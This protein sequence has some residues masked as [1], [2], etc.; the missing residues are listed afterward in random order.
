MPKNLILLHGFLGH[1]QEFEFL[2]QTLEERTKG[3][4]HCICLDLNL[5]PSYSLKAQADF[6]KKN[7]D[8]LNIT[9]SHFWGYSMGGRILLEFYKY[10]PQMCESL[11]LESVSLGIEDQKERDLRLQ[12]DIQWAQMIKTAPDTFLKE[13]YSQPLFENFKKCSDFDIYFL[14]RRKNLSSLHAKMI[15]E[16]SPGANT[17]HLDLIGNIDIPILSSVGQFDQKYVGLWGKLID[18]HSNIA[19]KVI[20]NSGHVIHIENPTGVIEEFMN[21]HREK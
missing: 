8:D 21:F 6:V 15:V 20:R 12:K 16:A 10:Y 1:P 5:A 3:A 11:T 2:T 17:A 4:F 13:W 14:L 9:K 18:K 19:I 7:L